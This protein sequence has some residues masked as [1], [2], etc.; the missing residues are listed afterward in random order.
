MIGGEAYL[1]SFLLL[2]LDVRVPSCWIIYGNEG[3]LE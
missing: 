1:A 2:D 3:K